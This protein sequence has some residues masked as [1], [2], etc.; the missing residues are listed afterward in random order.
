MTKEKII[1]TDCDG[2]ILDWETSFHK[3]MEAKGYTA[4]DKSLYKMHEAYDIEKAESKRLI[5]EYNESSWMLSLGAFRDARSGIARLLDEGYK[6]YVISSLSNDENAQ[7][8]RIMNLENV[9]GKEAFVGYTFLATGA[10]KDEV[11]ADVPKGSWWLEDKGENAEVGADLGLNSVLISHK[12]NEYVT[13]ER[14]ARFDTWA[15]IAE[16]IISADYLE[17]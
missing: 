13:D 7:K 17:G 4:E 8:L 6:F 12:H 16:H 9:F 3:W 2:I 1:Y 14:I 15:E 10:D 5:R 11:L